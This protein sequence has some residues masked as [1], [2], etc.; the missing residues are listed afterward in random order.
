M[1]VVA[2]QIY[3]LE[4]HQLQTSYIWIKVNCDGL[5][6]GC[7]KLYFSPAGCCKPKRLG[8]TGLSHQS[9]PQCVLSLCQRCT[10]SGF[11]DK[12]PAGFSTF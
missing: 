11:Q 5:A 9:K 10:G 2:E 4:V 12:S 3:W 8:N 1:Q 7:R 6:A